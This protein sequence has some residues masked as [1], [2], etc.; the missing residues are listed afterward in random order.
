MK[1][2]QKVTLPKDLAFIGRAAFKNCTGIREVIVPSGVTD[3]YDEAFSDCSNLATVKLNDALISI[4]NSAFKNC[5]YIAEVVIPE[6]VEHIGEEAFSSCY[7]LK[8]FSIKDA[9]NAIELAPKIIYQSGVKNLYIGRD[10]GDVRIMAGGIENIT[11]GNLVTQVCDDA[12]RG[13]GVKN[14]KFGSS[15]RT[16]G[17]SAFEG[18][19]ELSEVII[20][21]TVTSIGNKAF[22]NCNISHIAIG[23][24]IE[25]IGENAFGR[26]NNVTKVYVTAVN[27]PL[28]TNNSFSDYSAQLFVPEQS[29]DSYYNTMDCWYRFSGNAL[30]PVEKVE[31]ESDKPLNNLHPGD[32]VRLKA[33]VSPANADLPYIFWESTNPA[34]AKVDNDGVVTVNPDSEIAQGRISADDTA[35]QCKIIAKTLYGDI[36]AEVVLGDYSEIEDAVI[37]DGIAGD[38]RPDD[39]YTLQGICLK[40]NATKEDID[41]LPSGLYII[42]GKKVM[43]R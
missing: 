10:F 13:D 3:I 40:R 17:C 11:L 27:P 26:N 37:N 34:Y 9:E 24:G 23:S 35:G 5:G 16:I 33:T 39:I 42:G 41:A 15:I 14:L 2:I 22:Y 30:S 25:S 21:K 4:G 12:F 32:V 28:A 8:S 31:I 36:E 7:Y 6:S 43:K 18:C 29:L 20:P 38:K 1:T 19:T